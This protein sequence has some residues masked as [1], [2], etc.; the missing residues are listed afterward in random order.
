M[1]V[2]CQHLAQGEYQAFISEVLPGK[3]G[4]KVYIYGTNTKKK[5]MKF[6]FEEAE[7]IG[8]KGFIYK[9]LERENMLQ[10]MRKALEE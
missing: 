9:P 1:M 6:S 7:Q 3:D 8:T 10:R 4:D 2:R 5:A